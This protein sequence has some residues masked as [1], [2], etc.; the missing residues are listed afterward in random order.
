MKMRTKESVM[1][2]Q[3]EGQELVKK[4]TGIVDP[5]LIYDYWEMRKSNDLGVA[6]KRQC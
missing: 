6:F 2:K 5:I 4:R 1:K 3:A